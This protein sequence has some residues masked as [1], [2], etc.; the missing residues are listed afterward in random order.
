MVNNVTHRGDRDLMVKSPFMGLPPTDIDSAFGQLSSN[1]YFTPK[2]QL[3]WLI[4]NP[5]PTHTCSVDLQRNS[6]NV[7]HF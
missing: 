1:L 5:G 2:L 4:Y 3:L 7:S 6:N